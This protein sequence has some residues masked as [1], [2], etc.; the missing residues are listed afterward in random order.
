LRTGWDQAFATMA[1]Q[2]DEA[3][4]DEFNPTDWDQSEWEW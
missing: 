4:L 1:A 2:Q 3:L